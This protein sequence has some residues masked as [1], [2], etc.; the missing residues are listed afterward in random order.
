M[1]KLTLVIDYRMHNSSGIGTYI[2]NIVKFLRYEFDLKLI[3]NREPEFK[4]VDFIRFNSKIYSITEQIEYFIKL[5]KINFDI[6]WSPHYNVPIV[7]IRSKIKVTTIHDICHLVFYSKKDILKKMYANFFI[8]KALESSDILFTVS[9]YSA[10]EINK[11]FKKKYNFLITYN[12]VDGNVF[13]KVDNATKKMVSKKYM[14]PK[15]FILY[16]GNVKP[17]KNLVNLLQSLKYNDYNLVIVGKKDGFIIEDEVVFDVIEKEKLEDRVFFTGYVEY[18][19]L[20]VLYNLANLLVFPSLYEGFGLPP[21]EAQSCGCPVLCSDIDV[22]H[23]IYNDSV[24]YFN[25]YDAKDISN[26]IKLV[27]NNTEV[28]N[29]LICRGFENLKKYSW[30]KT[31]CFISD[32]FKEMF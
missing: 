26:K 11:Y 31:A 30:E 18:E 1:K 7:N 28:K 27:Y 17:H 9:H 5:K 32:T 4:D 6:F 10:N 20:P 8:K 12:A 25:P 24:I 19:E 13:K 23:E 16:V 2:K 14:L 3:S 29:D 21:L 22:L 15:D